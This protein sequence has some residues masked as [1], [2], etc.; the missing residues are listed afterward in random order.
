MRGMASYELNS[1]GVV[2]VVIVYFLVPLKLT[3]V[4]T[5]FSFLITVETE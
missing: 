3:M 5:L 1:R 2:V 4:L